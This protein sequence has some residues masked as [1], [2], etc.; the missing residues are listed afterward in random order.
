MNFKKFCFVLAFLILL[1][2]S[3]ARK[4]Q[5]KSQDNKTNLLSSPAVARQDE[6]VPDEETPVEEAPADAE[7]P[8]DGA[9]D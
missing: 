8:A 7:A 1:T 5:S 2:Q 4:A 6:M 9:A 3:Y